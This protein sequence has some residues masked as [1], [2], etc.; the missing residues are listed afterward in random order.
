[1]GHS[2]GGLLAEESAERGNKVITLNKAALPRGVQRKNDKN[3]TDVRTKNDLVSK[4]SFLQSGGKHVLINSESKNPLTEH[5]TNVL[6]R[7]DKEL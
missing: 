3:Q 6:D 2:L 4:L 5:S 1:M 7:I